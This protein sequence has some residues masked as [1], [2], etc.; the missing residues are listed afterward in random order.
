MAIGSL[1][2]PW[3]EA[4]RQ[5]GLDL[6]R[7]LSALG[8]SEAQLIAP[9]TRLSQAQ[10]RA[11][12]RSLV[13]LTG[14][15]ELGLR[16]AEQFALGDADLIGYLAR[17]ALHPLGALELVA[18]YARVLGDT[19]DFALERACGQV[20]LRFRLSGERSFE[21]EAADFTAAVGVHVLRELS[22]G[23]ALPL[24][25][26]LARARPHDAAR[27]RRFFAA[28]VA[29]MAPCTSLIYAEPPLLMP[30][31]QSDPQLLRILEERATEITKTLPETTSWLDRVRAEVERTLAAGILELGEVAARCG[32]SDRTLRRRLA[33]AQT[34]YR[35]LVDGLRR[36][37]ALALL[38]SG[39][40]RIS[41]LAQQLGYSDATAFA[42][43]FR[44]WTGRSPQEYIASTPAAT[45]RSL[46]APHTASTLR[47]PAVRD[48]SVR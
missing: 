48:R 24:A 43:A 14:D 21:P 45:L 10:G 18:R 19:A 16:A 13:A 36:E 41:A 20:I 33:A 5:H 42:R 38:R 2:R 1:Y 8:L 17:N 26:Q 11:L 46:P 37:R 44:R 39:Q 15:R 28:P 47:A 27:Y 35:E 40:P 31:A 4:A 12:V 23:R 34:S 30:F 6:T 7:T 9:G 22:C 25:V 3:L 29:F 32:M